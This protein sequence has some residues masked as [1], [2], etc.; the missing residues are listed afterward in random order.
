[1]LDADNYIRYRGDDGNIIWEWQPPADIE[2]AMTAGRS[3]LERRSQAY[4]LINAYSLRPVPPYL[5]APP[6]LPPA[7]T[8][9]ADVQAARAASPAAWTGEPEPLEAATAVAAALLRAAVQQ[10][11]SMTRDD[12]EW[13]A[14]TVAGAL[15]LPG[16]RPRSVRGHHVSPFG[17]DRSAASAAACLLMPALTQPGDARAL[18]DDEDLA[19]L[20]RD[21]C[22][23]NRQPVHRGP[24]DPGQEPWRPVWTAPCGPGPSGSDPVPPRHRLGCRSKPALVMSH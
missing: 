21:P 13:A 18:L 6:P 4:R 16:Q 24:D 19:A 15:S 23:R 11:G 22:H 17:A 12:L 3:D 1:M 8:L 9:T 14:V 7:Q 5:A 2:A 20:P 10:P